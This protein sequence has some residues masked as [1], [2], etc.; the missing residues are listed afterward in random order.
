MQHTAKHIP[1]SWLGL[2]IRPGNVLTGTFLGLTDSTAVLSPLGGPMTLDS[3]IAAAHATRAAL[4]P[5]AVD[6]HE[7]SAVVRLGEFASI[8]MADAQPVDR[9]FSSGADRG[10]IIGNPWDLPL[11]CRGLAHAWPANPSEYQYTKVPN[12]SVPTLLIGGHS[13]SKHRLRTRRRSCCH[14]YQRAPSHPVR[15]RAL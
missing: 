5:I 11:G 8:G 1:K 12:S 9:Y 6:Q 14:T 2:P 4:A 10:S 7:P 3:W 13:T 15:A